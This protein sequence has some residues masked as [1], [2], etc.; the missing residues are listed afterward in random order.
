MFPTVQRA[1]RQEDTMATRTATPTATRATGFETPDEGVSRDRLP[2]QGRVPEWLSGTLVRVTPALL[3]VG[4]AP[5]RHWFDGL[6]M[7]NAFR[8]QDGNVSYGSRFLDTDTNRRARAGESFTGF[9]QDPC[10]SLFRRAMAVVSGPKSD[11][12]NVNLMQLGDRYMAMTE[13]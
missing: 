1:L 2:L 11:N 10:R 9:A 7:L 13:I 5:M 12:A 8:V 6:A 3:D 4:G